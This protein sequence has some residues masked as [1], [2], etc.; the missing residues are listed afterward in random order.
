MKF[1]PKYTQEQLDTIQS[2]YAITPTDVLAQKMDLKIRTIRQIAGRLNLKKNKEARMESRT[3]FKKGS[4]SWN[5]GLKGQIAW[6]K[7][8]TGCKYPGM[9]K[10]WFKV[11]HE[12]HTTKYDGAISL[13]KE[14]DTGLSYFHIRIEKAKWIHLHR[15]IWEDAKGKIPAKMLVYF[16]DGNQLNCVLENLGLMTRKEN[17]QRVAHLAHEKNHQ[18]SENLSDDFVYQSFKRTHF[19]KENKELLTLEY[20]LKE[21]II[22]E[23]RQILL[24]NRS[25]KSIKNESATA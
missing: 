3:T 25:L 13:R 12:P 9:E 23:Q 18:R 20:C 17:I 2:L 5:T 7:G 14:H 4:T 19:F 24:L 6:N 16:K 15:K 11:G 22:E 1:Q 10:S 8:L 21:G